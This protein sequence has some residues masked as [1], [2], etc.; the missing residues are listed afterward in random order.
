MMNAMTNKIEVLDPMTLF[1][2]VG[3]EVECVLDSNKKDKTELL[4]I[5]D[6]Q[7][8]S[9]IKKFNKVEL[10][11][12][13]NYTELGTDLKSFLESFQKDYAIHERESKKTYSELKKK[14][15]K[16]KSVIPLLKNQYSN[17]IDILNDITDF[18]GVETEDEVFE[19]TQQLS[20]LYRL[21]TYD[22]I[23]EINL[24]AWLRR[25]EID[26]NALELPEYDENKL[27]N[28]IDASSWKTNIVNINYFYSLPKILSDFGIAL[29][30]VPY[31]P[32]TVYGAVR[33]IENKPLIQISDKGNDLASC[34][35]TLF[36]EI[37]HIILHKNDDIIFDD[38]INAP[39]SKTSEKERQANKFANKYL[40]NG[41]D[42]R[43]EVFV[44]K[45]SGK[46]V[47]SEFLSSK[48]NVNKLFTS[49]WLI[50]AQYQPRIQYRVP[51][52]FN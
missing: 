22:S 6:K 50:K 11:I 32:K 47:S 45:N 4:K 35:F 28:W 3:N 40:F 48:Y 27:I 15:N 24:K 52:Y 13:S 37:G 1:N 39:S 7:D 34:W 41:D 30:F 17:G 19:L 16:L 12:I 38:I 5:L 36:H 23:D 10:D 2:T 49:Y 14:Y 51:I 31:L 9:S 46:A 42:L 20:T 29:T 8:F 33:W 44:I 26:F 18:F 43:K 21:K 25:G